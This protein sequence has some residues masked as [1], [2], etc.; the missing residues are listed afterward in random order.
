M[1]NPPIFVVPI[2]NLSDAINRMIVESEVEGGVYLDRLAP[3]ETLEIETGDWIC[4]MEYCGGR[5]A[6]ISGHPQFCPEAV[7]MEVCGS[8]WSSIRSTAGSSPRGLLRFGL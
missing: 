1:R 8:T 2:P 7:E 6:V 3:G 4:R 5:R